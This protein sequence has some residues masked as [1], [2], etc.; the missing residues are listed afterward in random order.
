MAPPATP[1]I[2]C[3]GCVPRAFVMIPLWLEP[4]GTLDAMALACM[5]TGIVRGW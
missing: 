5:D 3:H 1:P 2:S 4:F